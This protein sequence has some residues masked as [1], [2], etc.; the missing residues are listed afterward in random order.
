MSLHIID[1]SN[2]AIAAHPYAAGALC[3]PRSLWV[4]APRGHLWRWRSS[5]MY[6]DIA[7]VAPPCIC[8]RGAGDA[9]P[10]NSRTGSQ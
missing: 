8:P 1:D 2:A 3:G 5:T 10:A 7:C 6:T 9:A 4:P